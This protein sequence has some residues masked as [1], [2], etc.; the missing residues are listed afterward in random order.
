MKTSSLPA[1]PKFM[2]EMTIQKKRVVECE[3]CH[4]ERNIPDGQTAITSICNACMLE[5]EWELKR[6]AGTLGPD[7]ERPKRVKPPTEAH[8]ANG[9]A[10]EVL[11]PH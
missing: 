8:S 3:N 2:S 6:R 1:K 9:E 11:L 7:D 10:S 4:A 5:L